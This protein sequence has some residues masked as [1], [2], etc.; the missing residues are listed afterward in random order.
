MSE[1]LKLIMKQK[2]LPLL[3]LL[4]LPLCLSAQNKPKALKSAEFTA[5]T[6]GYIK[7]QMDAFF[8]ELSNDPAAQAVVINYGTEREI[9]IREKQIKDAI[10]IRRYD[11]TRMTFV[12]GG[13]WKNVKTELWLV[14]PGADL[15][16]VSK[17][18]VIIDEFG[19]VPN[20]ESKARIDGLFNTLNSRPKSQGYILLYGSPK[21]ISNRT[22]FIKKYLLMVRFD[23]KRV[24]I[25]S[26]GADS[27][28]KT[29]FWLIEAD[30]EIK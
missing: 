30:E 9:L 20:G 5:A 11:E 6:N 10:K 14:P 23:A 27:K 26:A 2:L 28:G 25:K 17:M 22:M 24:I 12:R 1:K 16:E 3:M 21:F 8:V 29:E 13:F 7:M 15:P 18:A 4:I 19:N